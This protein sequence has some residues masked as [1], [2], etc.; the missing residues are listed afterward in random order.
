MSKGKSFFKTSTQSTLRQWRSTPTYFFLVWRWGTW[1]FA[2]V[3]LLADPSPLAPY[4]GSTMSICLVISF[5]YTAFV[6][7]YAPVSHLLLSQISQ[8]KTSALT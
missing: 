2:L 8:R 6:T 4:V 5:V 7:L 1:L 3:S